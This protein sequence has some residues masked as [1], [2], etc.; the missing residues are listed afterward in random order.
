MAEKGR[1]QRKIKKRMTGRLTAAGSENSYVITY[2]KI[3]Y[4]QEGVNRRDPGSGAGKTGKTKHNPGWFP[5]I[6]DMNRNRGTFLP[7]YKSV[8]FSWKSRKSEGFL[9]SMSKIMEILH[10]WKYVE[11]YSCNL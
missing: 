3:A 2:T 11:N 6:M 8:G 5:G 7:I 4:F 1:N 9:Q 10:I